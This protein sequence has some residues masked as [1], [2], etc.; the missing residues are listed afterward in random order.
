MVACP[1]CFIVGS[2]QQQPWL[3]YAFD[4]KPKKVLAPVF[5]RSTPATLNNLLKL[6][7]KFTIG[8][9][10]TDSLSNYLR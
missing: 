8:L 2:K 7:E 9:F 3:F 5:G 1:P 10:T 4:T 6:L